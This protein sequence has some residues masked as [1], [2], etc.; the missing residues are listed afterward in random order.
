MRFK[1]A[2]PPVRPSDPDS[3]YVNSW[4]SKLSGNNNDSIK[5]LVI[6]SEYRADG[7]TET[8]FS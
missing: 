1:N 5:W 7:C 2:R 6:V 3:G 4:R 8:L